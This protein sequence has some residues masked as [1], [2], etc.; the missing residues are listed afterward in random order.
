MDQGWCEIRDEDGMDGGLTKKEKMVVMENPPRLEL[1]APREVLIVIIVT[2]I[3]VAVL[4]V[5]IGGSRG[6]SGRRGGARLGGDGGA[7]AGRD[8]RGRH[9][10]TGGKGGDGGASTDADDLLLE[11]SIVSD[12]SALNFW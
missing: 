10:S 1:I 4:V 9:G 3:V 12:L 2:I 11:G 7:G 8:G 6:G 5:V